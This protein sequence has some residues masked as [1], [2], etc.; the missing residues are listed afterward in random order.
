MDEPYGSVERTEALL[1]NLLIVIKETAS[2]PAL[3]RGEGAR[4]KTLVAIAGRITSYH[5]EQ[6][7]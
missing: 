2:P 6:R 5:S 3:V 4:Q 7:S 1:S